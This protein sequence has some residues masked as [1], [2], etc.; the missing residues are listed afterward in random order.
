MEPSH[1]ALFGVGFHYTFDN[2]PGM[3]SRTILEKGH[4]DCKA[5]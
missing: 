1:D 2:F 5:R 4:R 3:I